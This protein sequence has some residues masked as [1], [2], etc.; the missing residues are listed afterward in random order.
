MAGMIRKHVLLAIAVLVAPVLGHAGTLRYTIAHGG[1]TVETSGDR[2]VVQFSTRNADLRSETRL[3]DRGWPLFVHVRG[4]DVSGRDVSETF[5]RPRVDAFFVSLAATPEEKAILARALLR[6]PERRLPLLP[7]GQ[8]RLEQLVERTFG[9]RQATLFAI[10]GLNAGPDFVWLDEKHDLFAAHDWYGT[11]IRDDARAHTGNVEAAQEKARQRWDAELLAKVSRKPATL[12]VTNARLFDPETGRLIP[13]TTIVVEGNR[14]AR[15]GTLVA[16]PEGAERIDAGGRVVLPGLWDMHVHVGGAELPYHLAAGVTTVRDVS[17]GLRPITEH[18][19]S[20]EDGKRAG[21]RILTSQ[22]L[23]GAIPLEEARRKI[24]ECVDLGCEQVKIYGSFPPALIAP[25][26]RYVHEKGLRLTGHIPAGT[27]AATAV[28]NGLDEIHHIN[29]VMLNFMADVK[30]T[31][32]PLRFTEPGLRGGALNVKSKN[33]RAFLA[34]LR[35][36]GVVV[37]PTVGVFERMFGTRPGEVPVMMARAQSRVP[38]QTYRIINHARLVPIEKRDE[39]RYRKS[40]SRMLEL[41]GAL[42]KAGVRIVAGTDGPAGAG[43]HRELEL[44]VE[45]GLSPVDALRSAT[46]VPAQVMR[47]DKDLGRVA[48]GMLADFI[49]VDGDPTKNISDIRRVATLVKD[50]AV[51]DPAA[52]YRELGVED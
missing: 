36:R 3:D 6:A 29:Q 7:H 4:K 25:V 15:T 27:I 31:D 42:H 23:N 10:V 22:F 14:I 9:G 44:Y 1:Q 40:Y 35:E 50:G 48:A 46:S 30:R 51:Y 43:L 49:I 8:A 28:A 26:A 38:A 11:T 16:I 41:V 2:I 34:D 5:Q 39:A 32:T 17:N 21:P 24:D 13:N 45:A 37:D 33:V 20:V 47:R 19:R 52:I 12:A 18:R